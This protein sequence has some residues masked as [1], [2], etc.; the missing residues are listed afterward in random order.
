MEV[1][2]FQHQ[3]NGVSSTG[4]VLDQE[5]AHAFSSPD[6]GYANS[7]PRSVN[8]WLMPGYLDTWIPGYFRSE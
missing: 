5:N 6:P 8:A 2:A 4:V 3:L 7:D 1:L